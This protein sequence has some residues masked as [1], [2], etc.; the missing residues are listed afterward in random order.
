MHAMELVLP[1]VRAEHRPLR[2]RV[3][4]VVLLRSALFTGLALLSV[5][6]LLGYALPRLHEE[7]Y[8]AGSPQVLPAAGLLKA[9]A[10]HRVARVLNADPDNT[11]I[12][13]AAQFIG[14]V[15]VSILT[16]H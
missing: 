11:A 7:L 9:Y 5:K 1:F 2:R 6:A 3:V 13:P 14:V 8:G 16:A 15:G 10:R 12:P 4:G